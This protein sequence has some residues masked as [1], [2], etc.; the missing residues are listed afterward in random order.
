[1][2]EK[3][4]QTLREALNRLPE[5][6]SPTDGWDRLH[7]NL[8]PTLSERLPSYQPPAEVWNAL[9]QNLHQEATVAR[10]SP[11]LAWRRN[12]IVRLTGMVAG[13]LLLLLAG[14]AIWNSVDQ[15]PKVKYA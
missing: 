12:P 6:A 1:M 3:N 5:Y 10:P 14:T 7:R 9:S 2:K 4:Y 11:K 13:F 15:G 8:T